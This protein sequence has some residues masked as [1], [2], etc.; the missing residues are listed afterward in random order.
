M[1]NHRLFRLLTYTCLTKKKNQK[2]WGEEKWMCTYSE[3]KYNIG[4]SGYGLYR[5][6]FREWLVNTEKKIDVG[7]YIKL[8]ANDSSENS[9]QQIWEVIDAVYFISSKYREDS[10]MQKLKSELVNKDK[11]GPL[12]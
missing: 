7:D 11:L 8:V 4:T 9:D 5:R 1:K 2:N 12:L 10:H 3:P 6:C